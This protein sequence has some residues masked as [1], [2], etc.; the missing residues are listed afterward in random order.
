MVQGALRTPTIAALD[1]MAEVT[2][3]LHSGENATVGEGGVN[4]TVAR[5]SSRATP[6]GG[7]A[8]RAASA[9]GHH[10]GPRRA[11]RR[12]HPDSPGGGAAPTLCPVAVIE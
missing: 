4:R 1:A 11:T 10:G 6:A 3:R 7:A 8:G 5:K 2:T 9:G 12:S